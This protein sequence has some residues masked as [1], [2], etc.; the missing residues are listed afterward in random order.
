[1]SF[2]LGRSVMC[3]Q[4]SD[5]PVFPVQLTALQVMFPYEGECIRLR[6]K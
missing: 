2:I 3:L 1:M 4:A 5:D 6:G